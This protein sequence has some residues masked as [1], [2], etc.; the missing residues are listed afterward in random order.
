MVPKEKYT[1]ANGRMSLPEETTLADGI[2][3]EQAPT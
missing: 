3:L 2:A 1:R